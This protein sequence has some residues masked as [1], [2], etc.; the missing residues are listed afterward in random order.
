[1]KK[2]IWLSILL[3]FFFGKMTAQIQPPFLDL[4]SK[5]VDSVL[6]SLSPDER[7]AQLFMIAAWSNKDMKHVR[8]IDSLISKYNFGCLI[9]MQGGP[10]R[11][12]K[13]ANYYQSKAKT[14]LLMSIDG[15]FGLAMRLDSTTQYPRQ[16]TLAA[17]QNDSLIYYMGRQIAR[18]CK[19]VGIHVN[20]APVI[21]INNNPNNPVISM[22]SFGEDK[23]AVAKKS[24]L[25]MK[26]M[27][28]EHVLACAKH[29]PGHGD[30][31]KDSHKTLP[32]INHSYERMD[33]LELYPFKY[34]M[35]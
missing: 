15:E 8:Q 16:M 30:T 9:F 35:E 33:S 4:E 25:Y 32:V 11:Q 1:M 24:Y 12:T 2:I 18:E 5:W 31:D 7:L 28:D 10:V 27:Q 22:R 34:L 20:F 17:M 21:D 23:T 13:L 3:S 6:T 29:F 14:P 19:A 26:G